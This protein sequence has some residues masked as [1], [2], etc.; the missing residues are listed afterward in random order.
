M[1]NHSIFFPLTEAEH[2]SFMECM[3]R[4]KLNIRA[5]L[6]LIDDI[7]KMEKANL[8][9]NR[10]LNNEE[11]M[12]KNEYAIAHIQILFSVLRSCDFLAGPH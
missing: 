1:I 11:A 3:F 10:L 9:A 4:S 12:L 5:I 6:P 8:E 2:H 7:I